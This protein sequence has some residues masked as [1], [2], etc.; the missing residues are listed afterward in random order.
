[1]SG[2]V[3]LEERESRFSKITTNTTVLDNFGLLKT[4]GID[5]EDLNRIEMALTGYLYANLVAAHG[6]N[7]FEF[8]IRLLKNYAEDILAL[9]NITPN[10]LVLPKKENCA[11]YNELH[12]EF[13]RAFSKTKMG[14]HI[15]RIQYPINIR[16]QNGMPNPV[17]DS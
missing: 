9:P 15:D 12:R 7:S 16:L 10:G 4:I 5:Q 11:A 3:S 8:S 17:I 13:A 6:Q 2:K 1:M 14:D